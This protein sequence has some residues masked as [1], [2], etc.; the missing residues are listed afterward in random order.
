MNWLHS[1]LGGRCL[2]SCPVAGLL[3]WYHFGLCFQILQVS[4]WRF[5][6]GCFSWWWYLSSSLHRCPAWSS[7]SLQQRILVDAYRVYL[8]EGWLCLVDNPFSASSSRARLSISQLASQLL[9]DL[10]VASPSLLLRSRP[11]TSC[12]CF[13][14]LVSLN[15]F[16]AAMLLPWL[17][18]LLWCF[19][20][21][22]FEI[23]IH[24]NGIQEI[25]KFYCLLFIFKL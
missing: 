13:E 16:Q 21:Q 10:P 7:P 11:G 5:A 15:C 14:A 17:P 24:E 19:E 18:R 8:A 3:R 25:I 4:S 22:A 9:K 2:F 1:R 12:T 23:S 6:Y 20:G